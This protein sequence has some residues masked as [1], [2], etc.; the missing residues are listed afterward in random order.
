ML[1]TVWLALIVTINAFAGE[2]RQIRKADIHAR[3][4]VAA[5]RFQN[6]FPV[7]RSTPQNITFSNPK[8]SE[9]YVDGTSIPE[10]DFDVGPSWAGLLPISGN[11]N[12]T[13]EPFSWSWGQ[14]KPTQ[15]EYSWTNL[16]SVLWVEQPVGTGFSQGVPNIKNEDELAAQLV[17][18]LQQ[19]LEV[20]S[21][22]KGKNFY[23]TGESYAG[24]EYSSLGY[25]DEDLK[26]RSQTFLAE[27]DALSAECNYADYTATYLTYPP[28]GL[29]PLPGTSTEAD[30][31]CDV[32]DRIFN[33]ALRLNPAFNIYRIFDTYPILWDVLGFPGSFPQEQ[34]SPLYFDRLD[35]KEAIHAPVNVSWV[36]CSNEDVFV[37]QDQSLPSAMSVLPN[38]IEKNNRTVIAHGL[39]DFVLI[40]EG[41][42]S[43]LA[44][45]LQSKRGGKQ[46]FQKPIANDSFI[47]DGV[48]ALGT[49][50][51]ERGLTYVEVELSGHMIP[52]FSPAVPISEHPD[53]LASTSLSL[54][55]TPSRRVRHDGAMQETPFDDRH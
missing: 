26:I 54:E 11:A 8:A 7:K 40:A 3:Q 46:G 41:T 36:E 38:V 23:V 48:G 15:N 43:V 45:E 20:F 44:Q 32:W 24:I 22:L 35:V 16:S 55:N 2:A 13:R 18:F 42:K 31:G 49:K 9:F 10:V 28:Q 37:H 50:H 17:G 27:L 30:K 1:S 19:F 14:A 4:A 39:A 21:E 6:N 12:E 52:Q 33:E 29:L 53:T 25:I 47:V 34:T 5:K 51:S